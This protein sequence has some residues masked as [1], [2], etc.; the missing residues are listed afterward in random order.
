MVCEASSFQ[1]E[2]TEAFAPEAAVLLNLAED[3]MDRYSGFGAYRAA[4]LRIFARQPPGTLAVVPAGLALADAGGAATRL[5]FGE[6][7][8]AA[9]SGAEGASRPTAGADAAESR[10]S[11]TVTGRS[12]GAAS[13]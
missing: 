5:T 13:R 1:L 7:G 3:H 2:D 12:T 9:A 6:A 11:P 10:T 8:V 4:K